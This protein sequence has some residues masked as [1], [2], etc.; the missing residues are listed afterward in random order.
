M[1]TEDSVFHIP[2]LAHRNF[3]WY[4]PR[5]MGWMGYLLLSVPLAIAASLLH[6]SPIIRFALAAVAIIPLAGLMGR[7]TE[8]LADRLGSGVGGLLN[9]TFGNAAELILALFAL[10]R[11]LDDIVKASLTGSIIGNLLLVLGASLFAGGLRFPVQRFNRTAAGVGSTLMALATIGLIVPALF[12]HLAPQNVNHGHRLSVAVGIILVLTY[13]LS[14]VFSLITHRTILGDV[15][16]DLETTESHQQRWGLRRSILVLISAT[17]FV[18]WMSEILVGAVE[19]TS[20][21]LGL[22]AVFMGV[23]VVAIV[24]NAAE[25]S[26]AV[27]MAMKNQMD[28]AVGIAFGSALQVAL[29]VAPVL[30]FASHLRQ[31]PMDLV[32]STME[33]VAVVLAVGV[34][35]MVAEDGE[36][37]WLEGAMLLMVYGILAVAFYYMPEAAAPVRDQANVKPSAVRGGPLPN[38]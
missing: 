35:R 12:H 2:T 6:G 27:L 18:A 36:S 19:A 10:G 32:F 5:S 13:F 22:N 1:E 38:F 21:S 25:H 17:V 33:V 8:Q 24:G 20:E 30:V 11:G 31:T 7:A 16:E 26:T 14:L 9:A 23:V 29:F 3:A 37:T 4:D 34:A 15:R 28:L